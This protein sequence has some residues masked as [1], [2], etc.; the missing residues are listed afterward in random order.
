MR[1][2]KHCELILIWFH[3]D[4]ILFTFPARQ[5]ALWTH[6]PSQNTFKPTKQWVFLHGFEERK[7]RKNQV[8][9]LHSHDF[10]LCGALMYSKYVHANMYILY[11][12]VETHSIATVVYICHVPAT[13][14]KGWMPLHCHS[15]VGCS[16]AWQLKLR[17]YPY[18]IVVVM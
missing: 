11:K 8:I 4:S 5:L 1:C 16:S 6:R 15:S 13:R 10:K 2:L 9:I 14:L 18:L 3:L 12:H 7:G 17:M